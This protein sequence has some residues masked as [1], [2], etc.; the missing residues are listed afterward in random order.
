MTPLH[1]SEL[2]NRKVLVLGLGTF[3][4]GVGA[5]RHLAK[6]GARVVATDLRSAEE[7][8]PAASALVNCGVD[9][10]LKG[11]D[12][13]MFE[14]A[15]VV[16]VNPAIPPASPWLEEA[17]KFGCRLT[18]EVSLALAALD[19]TPSL[20]VTGTHGKSTCAALTA[21]LVGSLPGR[22]VLAGNLGGSLLETIARL[23]P[24]DRLVVELSSFQLERL[25]SPPS[26]PRVA[27]LTV[28]GEDHLDWHGDWDA[29]AQAKLRLVRGRKQCYF[30]GLGPSF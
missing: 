8:G 26:W 3:G 17:R 5:A 18:T 20:A 6:L 14:R 25:E 19:G 7:L 23:G 21:H 29:Y 28:Q 4:G 1:P 13:E 10:R 30:I 2:E 15:D 22:T 24:D 16:V 11:H 12:S 9:L 27:I